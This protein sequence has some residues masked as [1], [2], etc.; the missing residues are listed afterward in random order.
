MRRG[1]GFLV[2]HATCACTCS[3]FA[4]RLAESFLDDCLSECTASISCSSVEVWEAS[5]LAFVDR[6]TEVKEV[7][8]SRSV[9]PIPGSAR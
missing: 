8:R 9:V 1:A 6:E 4:S 2:G 5:G 7:K 3:S